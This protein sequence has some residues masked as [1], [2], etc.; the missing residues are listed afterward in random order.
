MVGGGLG[1]YEYL[2]FWKASGL[3]NLGLRSITDGLL[4]GIVACSFGLLG[5]RGRSFEA[6]QDE[7]LC[8]QQ[9]VCM[10]RD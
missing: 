6:T 3:H 7:F 2:P 9:A 5:F 10:Q 8:D 4:C 1:L